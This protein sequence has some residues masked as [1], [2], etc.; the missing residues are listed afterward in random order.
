MSAVS[1]KTLFDKLDSKRAQL[2]LRCEQYAAWT[3][4]SKF[5][6]KDADDNHEMA[7]DFQAVGAKLVNNLLNKVMLALFAPSRPF[8][9]PELEDKD[10]AA[11]KENGLAG[12]ALDAVLSQV[13][14]KG[15]KVL[16]AMQIRAVLVETIAQLIITGNSLL[17]YDKDEK[18]VSLYTLRD[19]V[20]KRSVRGKLLQFILRETSELEAMPEAV[21]AAY[22]AAKP[23]AKPE[24][25]VSLYT[26]LTWSAKDKVWKL[27]QSVDA[28]DVTVGTTQYRDEDLPYRV[29]TWSLAPKRMYGT[30]MVEEAQGAFHGLS[31]LSSAEIPG[32][33][34]MCRIIHLADPTGSTDAT[35]FQNALS[36]AVLVGRKDDITT[37]DLGGKARDYQSVAVKIEKY[38]RILSEMFLLAT[39]AVRASE[40]TT[41]EEIRLLANELETSVGGV[42]SRLSFDLQQ[43]LAE[44][45]IKEIQDTAIRKLKVYVITGLDALSANGD[46][47]NI[48]AFQADLAATKDVPDEIKATFLWDS[49]VQLLASLHGVDYFKF[50][51]SQAEVKAENA[52][53]QEDAMAQQQELQAGDA[54]G[55]V[56]VNQ[57]SEQEM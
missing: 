29:L 24:T 5:P 30:G 49:Y 11:L 47:D 15:M 8:F 53:A 43:W 39:G 35:E 51:R 16:E 50:L 52:Q 9:R 45:A 38:E 19:Y 57:L 55:K 56:A 23:T 48:R 2:L 25:T 7:I 32:L 10:I 46:L 31:T 20:C 21:Q 26:E 13:A 22:R 17:H 1:P 54:L 3:I 36:G 34:E 12:A 6:Q 42:Y 28:V 14:K 4:P 33:L 27:R 40:R 37:P 18:L 44:L 41:A